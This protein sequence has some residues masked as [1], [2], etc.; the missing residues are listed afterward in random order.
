[1]PIGAEEQIHGLNTYVV[2]NKT[3]PKAI[4]VV[5]SDIFG[6]PLPNNKLICD[7]YA[8]NGDYLVYMPDFFKG[9]PVPL[10]VADVL[11]PVD[12]SKQSLL[13]KYGGMLASAPSLLLWMRRHTFEQTE[14]DCMSFLKALRLATPQ[15]TKIGMVGFCWGGRFALRAG[16]ESN[17]VEK[18]GKKIGL[19]DAIVALHPSF[20]SIPD[21][22]K[23]MVVPASYGWGLKD[24]GVPYQNKAK[25]EEAHEEAKKEGKQV[26]EMDHQ[27]Y[28]PGRHGFA[29]RGN[30]EDPIEKKALE[31]SEQQALEFFKKYL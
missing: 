25:V 27:T 20:L 24:E 21:D 1:M 12:A 31:D 13:G 8:K 28:D 29:V 2:G 11:L 9:D 17:M 30:P 18:D 6:L 4:I 16:L 26:P 14:A 7:S 19:I 15:S 23:Y 22:V 10:K 5:Y 3:D